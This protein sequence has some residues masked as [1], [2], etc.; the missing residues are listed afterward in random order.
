MVGGLS[1]SLMLLFIRID[2]SLCLHLL[3]LFLRPTFSVKFPELG[4]FK[5][6]RGITTRYRVFKEACSA[7]RYE[8]VLGHDANHH[9]ADEDLHVAELCDFDSNE[10]LEVDL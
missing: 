3:F 8:H 9:Q 4:L 1:T 2:H 5:L 10:S 7:R 6:R